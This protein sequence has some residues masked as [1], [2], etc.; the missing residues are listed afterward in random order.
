M[1]NLV[2]ALVLGL[3]GHGGRSD[4]PLQGGEID[5]SAENRYDAMCIVKPVRRLAL[6]TRPGFVEGTLLS[7]NIDEAV[8]SGG[9]HFPSPTKIRVVI[10][11]SADDGLLFNL[12]PKKTYFLV[13][14]SPDKGRLYVPLRGS[15]SGEMPSY[16]STNPSEVSGL[17]IFETHQ[18]AVSKGDSAKEILLNSV[19]DTMIR[20]DKD[21]IDRAFAFLMRVSYWEMQ[22]FPNGRPDFPLSLRLHSIASAGKQPYLRLKIYELLNSWHVYGSADEY[23]KSVAAFAKDPAAFQDLEEVPDLAFYEDTVYGRLPK[24][25]KHTFTADQWADAVLGASNQKVVRFLLRNAVLPTSASYEP[26]L[27]AL[28]Q[29][30]DLDTRRMIVEY[31]CT[32]ERDTDHLPL[33]EQYRD[34]TSH[35]MVYTYPNLNQVV[36]Y[37]KAKFNIN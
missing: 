36:A 2:A 18:R 3:L 22:V 25:F 9:S 5:L 31:L 33:R 8:A 14:G 20:A 10:P 7:V 24:D 11:W 29:S 15:E 27:A 34:P 30:P 1:V 32:Q 19:A 35:E 26:K 17:A 4:F 21:G 16:S 12:S 37:W 23:L 6:D 13:A 28:L